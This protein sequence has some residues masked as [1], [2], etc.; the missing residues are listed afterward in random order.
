MRLPYFAGAEAT[1]ILAC[2]RTT[3]LTTSLHLSSIRMA[4]E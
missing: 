1:V 4:I 2:A 3:I